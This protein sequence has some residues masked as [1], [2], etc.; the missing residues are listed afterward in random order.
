MFQAQTNAP[1]TGQPLISAG[2][3]VDIP[4]NTILGLTV[5]IFLAI[6]LGHFLSNMLKN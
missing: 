4:T 2:V 3:T 6:F 5:G 1:G